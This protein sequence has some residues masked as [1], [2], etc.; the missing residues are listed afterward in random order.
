[1]QFVEFLEFIGRLADIKFRQGAEMSSL[2]LMQKIDA[3]LDELCPSFG[4]TKNDV[5]VE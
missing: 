2:P 1:M 4:L 3:I 5:N